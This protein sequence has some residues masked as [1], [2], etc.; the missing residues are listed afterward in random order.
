MFLAAFL[1][2]RV[3]SSW[4]I[5]MTAF[6][7]LLGVASSLLLRTSL[8]ANWEWLLFALLLLPIVFIRPVQCMLLV[9]LLSGLLI[10]LW[11]GSVQRV[12]LGG[13][14]DFLN[15]EVVIK[16]KV[17]EDVP[18]QPNNT[19]EI[20]IQEI[21]VA[22]KQLPGQ[23]WVSALSPLEI[24]R[25]DVV[26][27]SGILKQGFGTFPGSMSYAKIEKVERPP[28]A[29]PARDIRD[30]FTD[31]V[32]KG[33]PEPEAS[34]GVGYLTGQRSTLPADFEE[35]LRIVGL[36]HV[37]VASG[38]NLTILVRFARR[39]FEK[40]SKYLAAAS[41]GIMISGF[42][43]VTGFSPSMSRAGLVAGLSL[44]AWYYGRT[45]HP[46]VLLPF[47]AAITLLINPMYIWGDL[48]WYLSFLSFVGVIIFSP[49]VHDYFWGEKRPGVI[50][51]TLIDTM[52]AQL[53]TFPLLA[54]VFGEY[55]PY[56]LLANLLV[57]PLIPLTMVL[58]FI[59]GV[60]GLLLPSLAQTVGM[61]ADL[62][63]SYMVYIVEWVANLPGA[64]T[65]L[66][67]TL[68]A[69]IVSYIIILCV[70]LFMRQKTKHSFRKESIVE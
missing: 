32:R 42:M 44:L 34:L 62:I 65:E 36:T 39:L 55:S 5:A 9:A 11:R 54:L 61:P 25:S 69:M 45:V 68:A 43:L 21:E 7:V 10:G 12:E 30:T 26:T 28:G 22:G 41:G 37:V 48:G 67:F 64:Q 29:D 19:L 49:L 59:T 66:P 50:R 53:I 1:H 33:I 35:Q 14:A 24:K 51:Q 20:R 17:A 60:T 15:Q 52:S 2:K 47:T 13:Y 27:L 6:G 63:L 38:Y 18:R 70:T 23:V 58:T 31:G 46:L 4:L 16:G 8:L 3:H 56:A 57:L 40:T